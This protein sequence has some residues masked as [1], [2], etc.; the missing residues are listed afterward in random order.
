MGEIGYALRRPLEEI[1]PQ[2]IDKESKNNRRG[3]PPDQIVQ[4]D[5]QGITQEPDEIVTLEKIDKMAETDP[6]TGPDA[7]PERIILKGYLEAEHGLIVKQT[8]I[9]NH[10]KKHKIEV[11]VPPEIVF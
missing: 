5:K 7:F 1:P 10:R 2:L 3:K 9:N 8:E 6:W 11:L 4:T